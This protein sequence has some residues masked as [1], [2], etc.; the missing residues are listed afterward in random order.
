VLASGDS[1]Q[2]SNVYPV[3]EIL[4]DSLSGG[5][6]FAS[7]EFDLLDGNIGG[8]FSTSTVR[9]DAGT[10]DLVRQRETV[11][12]SRMVDG[13]FYTANTRIVPGDGGADTLRTLVVVTNTTD[14]P[15]TTS[16]TPTCQVIVYAYRSQAQRD[17]IPLAQAPLS[18]SPSP[19]LFQPYRFQLAPGQSWV[20]GNDVLVSRVRALGGPGHYWFSAWDYGADGIFLSAGDAE[21][22]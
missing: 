5:R 15:V 14:H 3:W 21:I 20:F 4:G 6:Y 1:L 10:V 2:F 19:C 17:S 8:S 9:A 16:T 12:L 22:R 13:V 18:F 11:P 7:A